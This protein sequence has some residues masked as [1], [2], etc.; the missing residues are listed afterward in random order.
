MEAMTILIS[1][2]FKFYIINSIMWQIIY[3]FSIVNTVNVSTGIS[4]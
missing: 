3:T 4:K 2:A 1:I